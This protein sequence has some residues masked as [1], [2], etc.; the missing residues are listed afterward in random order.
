MACVILVI[1][2]QSVNPQLNNTLIK[3]DI[4]QLLMYQT[5]LPDRHTHMID[6]LISLR[7][8]E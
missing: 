2:K 7:L 8:F 1:Q 5:Y 4:N 6:R 3:L